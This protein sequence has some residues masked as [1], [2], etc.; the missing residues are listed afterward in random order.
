MMNEAKLTTEQR[1]RLQNFLEVILASKEG[2]ATEADVMRCIVNLPKEDIQP[3]TEILQ[4][5]GE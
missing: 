2:N 5:M 3:F 4:T 1:D